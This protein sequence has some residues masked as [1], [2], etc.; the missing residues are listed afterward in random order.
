MKKYIFLSSIFLLLSCSSLENGDSLEKE[1][2][3][4]FSSYFYA[5]KPGGTALIMIENKILYEKGF[6]LADLKTK[7]AI[8]PNTIFNTGSISKTFVS[9]GIL[10]LQERG[11]LSLEDNLLKYFPDFKNKELASKVKIINL[12][13][14]T[15]GLPDNRGVADSTQ[16]Y[17]TADDAQNFAPL[18]QNDS[19][20]FEP[21][22]FFKYSN[23]SY[24]GLALIIEQVTGDSWQKF[25]EKE[26]FDVLSMNNSRITNGAYPDS[27]VSH[28]YRFNDATLTFEEEDYGEVPTFNAAGNG[29]VWSTVGDIAKYKIGLDNS[30]F[31]NE[32]MISESQTSYNFSNWK[33]TVNAP[34]GYSWFINQT[35]SVKYVGHT[36]SQGGFISDFLIIKEKDITYILLCNTPVPLSEIRQKVL[37]VLHKHIK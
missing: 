10:I 4:I 23:P 33:D 29:G 22:E 36:G 3:V 27:G 15:S 1:L 13:T 12:L 30:S 18:K 16:Y 31:L 24:N 14:H 32:K 25:I 28:A 37:D 11:M 26:I 6:G 35:D 9:N 20:L 8:D 7:D 21:G 5:D 34:N 19:L 2:D 17:L